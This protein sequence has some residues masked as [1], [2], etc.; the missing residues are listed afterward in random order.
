MSTPININ[1]QACGACCH[2][3]DRYYAELWPKENPT[4]P[5]LTE[6]D[7][8]GS[9]FMRMDAEKGTCVALCGT[10]GTAVKCSIYEDRPRVCQDFEP[11]GF[12]CRISQIAVFGRVV[13][14]TGRELQIQDPEPSGG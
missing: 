6:T 4:F 13:E 10:L 7:D 9:R 1:C 12:A 8:K 11:D 3:T 14:T 2:S 5:E